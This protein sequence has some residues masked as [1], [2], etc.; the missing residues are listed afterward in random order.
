MPVIKL[1]HRLAE[2]HRR[3][4][5]R[6]ALL[7][8]VDVLISKFA[9]TQLARLFW[10]DLERRSASPAFADDIK[11][12]FLSADEVLR[13]SA[14]ADYDLE[15]AMAERIDVRGDLCL[16]AFVQGALASYGWLAF[17]H[18]EPEHH[19]GVAMAF[20]AHVAYIYKTFTVPAFRGHHLLAGLLEM[21][22]PILAERGTCCLVANVPWTN[23]SS[24][25]AFRRLGFV[26]IGLLVS[27]RL[28][29]LFAYFPP[30][31][32]GKYGLSFSAQPFSHSA[33]HSSD[34]EVSA[35]RGM[36]APLA[37]RRATELPKI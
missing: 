11:F 1:L 16:A 9:G 27:F 36:H 30:R 6:A 17:E 35:E 25:H 21:A 19:G 34:R 3:F 32:A 13:F 4:G 7:W 20:P 5:L 14:D 28:G 8:F 26:E 15:A 22:I 23:W 29:R 18:I 12:R 24:V 33:F 2:T 37:H 10:L 31:R